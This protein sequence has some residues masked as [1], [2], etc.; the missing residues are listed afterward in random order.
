MKRFMFIGP[1]TL[2]LSATAAPRTSAR[3]EEMRGAELLVAARP[4]IPPPT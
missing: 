1:L 2:M 3:P 4:V